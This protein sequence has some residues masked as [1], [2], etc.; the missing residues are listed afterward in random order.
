MHLDAHIIAA[1]VLR[2]DASDALADRAGERRVAPA[3]ATSMSGCSNVVCGRRTASLSHR[4]QRCSARSPDVVA[5]RSRDLIR[6]PPGGDGAADCLKSYMRLVGG[7]VGVWRLRRSNDADRSI[8][9]TRR[10]SRDRRT[11]HPTLPTFLICAA[12]VRSGGL[13]LC[14]SLVG[15]PRHLCTVPTLGFERPTPLRRSSRDIRRSVRRSGF[16]AAAGPAAAPFLLPSLLPSLPSPPPSLFFSPPSL[17]ATAR[18]LRVEKFWR[19]SG[20]SFE[21]RMARARVGV[22]V[23]SREHE[24]RVRRKR[25]R[26]VG[27]RRRSVLNV[28]IR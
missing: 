18:F 15:A 28:I 14:A 5:R 9:R 12:T 26:G 24:R 3:A 25:R 1:A 27:G 2:S 10:S 23:G 22:G 21:R 16:A 11:R 17:A 19:A 13:P 8:R 6:R 20:G 4:R 7:G